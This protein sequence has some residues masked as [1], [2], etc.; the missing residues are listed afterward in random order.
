M[1]RFFLLLNKSKIRRFA[2]CKAAG[3]DLQ[4]SLSQIKRQD[5]FSEEKIDP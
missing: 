1:L 2:L 4:D 3:H 5:R